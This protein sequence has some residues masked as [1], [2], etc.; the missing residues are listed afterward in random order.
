MGMLQIPRDEAQRAAFLDMVEGR[1]NVEE[2][3]QYYGARDE[4]EQAQIRLQMAEAEILRAKSDLV[5]AQ[6]QQQRA[7]LDVRRRLGIEDAK[8]NTADG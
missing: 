2:S 7:L 6:T 8:E 5:V 3:D 4:V 1:M